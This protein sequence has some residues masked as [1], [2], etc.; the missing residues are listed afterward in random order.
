MIAAR[1]LAGIDRRPPGLGDARLGGRHRDLGRATGNERG[2][3]HPDGRPVAIEGSAGEHEPA[4]TPRALRSGRDAWIGWIEADAVLP[5]DAANP[6]AELS[7]EGEKVSGTALGGDASASQP[8]PRSRRQRRRDNEASGFEVEEWVH[9][10]GRLV[11]DDLWDHSN[12]HT[13][14]RV[15]AERKW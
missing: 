8:T 6:L 12:E 9:V 1:E 11:V 10:S 5:L 3:D 7:G 13:C 15:P 4:A 14:G 2:K